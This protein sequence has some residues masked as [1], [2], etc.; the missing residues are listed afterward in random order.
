[1]ITDARYI[2][3]IS[4]SISN[5]DCEACSHCKLYYIDEKFGL[6]ILFGY[7]ESDNFKGSFGWKPIEPLLN[8]ERFFDTDKKKDPGFELNQYQ[9]GLI[10]HSDVITNYHFVDNN[11]LEISPQY[12][13]W[14]YNDKNGNIIFEI[15][16]IYDFFGIKN[17]KN[18]NF[19]SYQNFIKTY[20]VI[21]HEIISREKL[22]EWNNQAKDYNPVCTD[23]KKK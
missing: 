11:P 3:L 8:N 22:I 16:P 10:K 14:M 4:E 23:T 15:S 5:N 19:I 13:S 9:Q 6:N 7:T 20:K 18:L 21:V 1:M 17:K 12:S 2:H